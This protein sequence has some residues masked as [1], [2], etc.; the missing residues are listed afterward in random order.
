MVAHIFREHGLWLGPTKKGDHSNPLGYFENN[1]LKERMKKVHGFDVS[2]PM[3]RTVPAWK[4]AVREV[5]HGQG[6]AGERWGFKTGVHYWN[7]WGDFEPIFIKVMRNR[8]AIVQSYRKY[9]GVY[10][11]HGAGFIDRGLGRLRLLPGVEVDADALILGRRD[12]I[13]QSVNAV[14][15][16]YNEQVVDQI[17]NP[18]FWNAC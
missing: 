16:K 11:K 2:G 9:G 17:V 13:E 3:P 14:G 4:P 7:V 15:L 6:Y 1:P 12:Q 8:D 18:R 10:P 5:L